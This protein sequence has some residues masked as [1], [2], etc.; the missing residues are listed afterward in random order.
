[1][2]SGNVVV[3]NQRTA[4]RMPPTGDQQMTQQ[5]TTEP[6]DRAIDIRIAF[7]E[8]EN[9]SRGPFY[10]VY[11]SGGERFGWLCSNCGTLNVAM[12]TMGRI[13]CNECTNTHKAVHW[14]AA[15]L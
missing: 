15:Y 4:S 5:H 14:D 13:V 2:V 9:G 12:D 8:P 3:P 11:A 10:A 7:E 6:T 1:M